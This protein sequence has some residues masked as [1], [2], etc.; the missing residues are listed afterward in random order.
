MKTILLASTLAL[1]MGCATAI[2][3]PYVGEQ[4]NWPTVDGSIVNSKYD[5]PV[6]NSL[7]PVAYD[8]VGE[9][10]IES[11]FYA[12][13]E[14][15]HMTAL[16]AKAKA[17]GAHAVVLVDGQSFFGIN[18]GSRGRIDPAPSPSS[19]TPVQIN[20]FLPESFRPGVCAIAIRW[21]NGAP[22][23]LPAK[24]A[25]LAP[26]YRPGAKPLPAKPA[27]EAKPAIKKPVETPRSNI[28]PAH[29]A[30]PSATSTNKPAAKPATPK[31]TVK[32]D[33]AR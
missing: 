28:V 8:V 24:Y 2:M 21:L 22:P 13:P 33:E 7:P 4:Q 14:E 29:P 31:K 32:P 1:A 30:Q 27:I 16:A 17:A 23:G 26:I 19:R 6:F 3:R 10:R 20:R 5:L 15:H 12:Q 9:L 11:P 25:S 18:Y